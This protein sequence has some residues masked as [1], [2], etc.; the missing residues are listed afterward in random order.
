MFFCFENS[1]A[2]SSNWE[3]NPIV[4]KK[5]TS[6]YS[7]ASILSSSKNTFYPIESLKYLP[8]DL[9]SR[10]LEAG[11]ATDFSL[12]GSNYE[13]V[14]VLVNGKR[15]NDPRSGHQNCDIPLTKADLEDLSVYSSGNFLN[16]S[17]NGIGGSFN[18]NVK[19]ANQNKFIS[20]IS[21][22]QY[23]TFSELF[24]VEKT[25]GNVGLRV[26][27]ENSSS[28]GYSIDTDFNKQTAFG[29]FS[30]TQDV[31]NY[32][33]NWG[34]QEKDFG[35]YD[36]YTPN[37]G[38]Q[39]KENTRVYMLDSSLGV[40]TDFIDIKPNFTWRR[41][42][43]KFMLDK[44]QTRSRYINNHRTDVYTPALHF[45]K[46]SELLGDLKF[47][48]EYSQ[49]KI[50]S[51]NL[52]NHQRIDKTCFVS[53]SKEILSWFSYGVFLR[54]DYYTLQDPFYSGALNLFFTLDDKNIFFGEIARNVRIPSFTEIYY[55]DPTTIGNV[56]LKEEKALTYK[57]GYKFSQSNFEF[58][59]AVFLRKERDVIDWVKLFASDA[60]WQAN[61]I[62]ETNVLGF[63]ESLK[64]N[65]NNFFTLQSAYIFLNKETKNKSYLYK[66]GPSYAKHQVNNSL[67]FNFPFGLQVLSVNYKKRPQRDGWWLLDAYFSYNLNKHTKFFCNIDNIFNQEYQEI[68]GVP[69]PGRWVSVGLRCEW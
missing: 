58:K 38:Y 49:E 56:G 60:K 18:F 52:G 59:P 1:Y 53:D 67:E 36:F 17:V 5:D 47:G 54:S 43:D 7:D 4:I 63:E 37:S 13:G 24:S 66:Y 50:T 25:V 27:L 31:W 39:S 61:N 23:E 26:S 16:S 51:N 55:N 33:F 29:K 57:V 10:N 8:V 12:K 15:F 11:V 9:Q 68:V 41:H 28:G 34:F 40:N 65:F 35:A 69:Q 42:H 30:Y 14:A 45:N 64:I 48:F 6:I 46:N 20:E 62:S 32:D 2:D 44:T 19:K 22:G 21:M 3:L